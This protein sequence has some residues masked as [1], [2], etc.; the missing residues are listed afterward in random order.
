MIIII[1]QVSS[2]QSLAEKTN[3]QVITVHVASRVHMQDGTCA[4]RG[5]WPT[6]RDVFVNWN[7]KTSVD[8]SEEVEG[9]KKDYTWKV[10]EM[11]VQY[12][13]ATKG[14]RVEE[15]RLGRHVGAF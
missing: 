12:S 2:S 4:G 11:R 6:A 9:Q 14:E 5:D 1:R 10:L 15:M 3:K 8:S 7:L 13:W